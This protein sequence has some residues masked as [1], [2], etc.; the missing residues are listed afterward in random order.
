[1]TAVA[2]I[3][4]DAIIRT[5]DD[6]KRIA[7]KI[8]SVPR[9]VKNWRQRLN[10][11]RLDETIALARVYDEVA[12]ALYELLSEKTPSEKTPFER[13]GAPDGND[14]NRAA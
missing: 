9:T 8:G 6:D 3:I 1:M 14:R 7:R 13:T 11:P 2:D 4:A 12:D 5:G 10:A